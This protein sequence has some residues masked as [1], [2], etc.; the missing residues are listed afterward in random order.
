MAAVRSA[1][2]GLP[3][4]IELLCFGGGVTLA[5]D[6]IVNIVDNVFYLVLNPYPYLWNLYMILFGLMIAIYDWPSSFKTFGQEHR[7]KAFKGWCDEWL[8]AFS[9]LVYRGV[10]YIAVGSLLASGSGISSSGIIGIYLIV[11]G[12]ILVLLN[13]GGGAPAAR[14]PS[15]ARD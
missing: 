4:G 13:L 14:K 5:V 15:Q 7:I 9:S 2:A 3:V 10:S 1:V 12:S 11:T 8:K 6:S